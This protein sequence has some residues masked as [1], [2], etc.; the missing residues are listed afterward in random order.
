MTFKCVTVLKNHEKTAYMPE[1]PFN[2]RHNTV[3]NLRVRYII[4]L[5]VIALLITASFITMQHV[6]SAQSNFSSLINLSGH[7]A[8]LANRIAYFSSLMASTKDENEFDM[9]R[10]Q[11]G[12][13]V[14]KMRAAYGILRKGDPELRT[15]N[16]LYYQ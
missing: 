9:A 8:G 5:S 15:W 13:T 16:T 3:K 1:I 2:G 6:I 10:A 4:G 11:V 7:Q 12:R 14:E